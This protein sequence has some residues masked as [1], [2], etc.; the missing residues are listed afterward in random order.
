MIPITDSGH[1][2]NTAGK[3]SEGFYLP[4]GKIELKEN[5]V[6]EAVANKLSALFY[7]NDVESYFISQEWWDIS[8]N[9]RCNRETAIAKEIKKAGK[10]SFFLSIHADAFHI[11]NKAKGGRFFYHSEGGRKL[12]E[13]FTEYLKNNGYD[14]NLREPKKANF[15]VLR[16]TTSPAILFEMG[17]MTTRSDLD[18]LKKDSFRNK[19]AK[20]LYEA[21]K[22]L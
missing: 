22:E 10:K 19:T 6:N 7:F 1:G 2:F 8:L 17:F 20:L 21:T 14:L 5:S 18:F 11:K 9:E 15:K 13:H 16:D 12:A 3:R 4:N